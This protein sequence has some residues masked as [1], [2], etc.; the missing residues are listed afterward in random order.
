MSKNTKSPYSNLVIQSNLHYDGNR[1]VG[2]KRGPALFDIRNPKSS[3]LPN[4]AFVPCACALIETILRINGKKMA[5]I[6]DE[7]LQALGASNIWNYISSNIPISDPLP[8][9]IMENIIERKITP[10][11]KN[12]V[13]THAKQWRKFFKNDPNI[14]H[15]KELIDEFIV[16][17]LTPPENE[18][19][20]PNSV[21]SSAVQSR[22]SKRIVDPEKLPLLFVGIL[23]QAFA[24]VLD[25][26]YFKFD[27]QVLGHDHELISNT[28]KPSNVLDRKRK[29]EINELV[30]KA[31]AHYVAY[32]TLLERA[33]KFYKG[34]ILGP[35]CADIAAEYGIL[36][37][38]LSHETYYFRVLTN[39]YQP[40]D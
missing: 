10:F 25:I 17:S 18:S 26:D 11:P 34:Y 32:T 29:N 13:E 6:F 28:A 38:T 39:I 15:I 35:S 2:F 5:P 1:R 22:R 14:N 3:A 23:I 12:Y 4:S 37:S 9:W 16:K 19:L 20:P 24:I 31:N 7:L 8:K 33:E 21:R 36:T 27:N 40:D 30:R